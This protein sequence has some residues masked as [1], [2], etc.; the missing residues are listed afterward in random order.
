[1]V[2]AGSALLT[3]PAFLLIFTNYGGGSGTGLLQASTNSQ[4]WSAIGAGNTATFNCAGDVA[5]DI[6]T[7]CFAIFSDSQ[8][9]LVNGGLRIGRGFLFDGNVYAGGSM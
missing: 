8:S 4:T 3:T 9:A 7:T 1:M 5:P 2:S 6:N